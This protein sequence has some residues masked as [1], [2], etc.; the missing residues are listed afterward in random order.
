PENDTLDGLMGYIIHYADEFFENAGIRCRLE[1]PDE[2]PAC[3]LSAELRHNLFLM[4]KESFNNIVK[5]SRATVVTVSVAAINSTAHIVVEDNGCGFDPTAVLAKSKRSGLANMS[6][7]MKDLGGEFSIVSQPGKGARLE[8][9]V[10]LV[11]N[12]NGQR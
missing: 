3:E 12:V 4:I 6:R 11:R 8:F 1:M 2:P 9:A 5:H 10:K 7:R